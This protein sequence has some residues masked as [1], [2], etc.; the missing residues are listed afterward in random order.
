MPIYEFIAKDPN[1]S[2]PV[3]R[4]GFELLLRVNQCPPALCPDC[5]VPVRKCISVPNVGVSVSNFDDRAKSTGFHKL[6]KT[7]QGEYEKLY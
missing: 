7:G 1:K 3:C 5:G 4:Q 6:K 2:C